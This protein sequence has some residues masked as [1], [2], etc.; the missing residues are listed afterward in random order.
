VLSLE[1]LS[2]IAFICLGGAGLGALSLSLSLLVTHHLMDSRPSLPSERE[3]T[4]KSV[5]L[6]GLNYISLGVGFFLG[7]QICAP[8]NDCIYRKLKMRN[9]N[10]G[11]PEFHVPLMIPGACLVPI[12]LFIYGWTSFYQNALDRAEYW[13]S[14]LCNWVP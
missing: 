9:N 6:G 12:G 11:R 8:I 3:R 5:S 2:F 7:T 13:G 1:L 10:I 14:Y 4:T